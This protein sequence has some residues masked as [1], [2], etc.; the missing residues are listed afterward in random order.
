MFLLRYEQLCG[1]RRFGGVARWDIDAGVRHLRM[2][3]R[4]AVAACQCIRRVCNSYSAILF[5]SDNT[6]GLGFAYKRI[7]H[8]IG[9]R[10]PLR[11]GNL[12][13]SRG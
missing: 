12:Q 8:G 2:A 3:S 9:F 5:C 11:V 13:A 7:A 4:S 10:G 6:Y 1:Q